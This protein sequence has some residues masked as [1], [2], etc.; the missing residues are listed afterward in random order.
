MSVMFYARKLLDIIDGSLPRELAKSQEEWMDRDAAY[1]SIIILAVDQKLMQ[2]LM[3]C[4]TANQM[5]RRL[6]TVHEQNT[7]E[8]LQLLQQKFYELKMKPSSDMV[9]H[10]NAVEQ[11]AKQLTDLGELILKQALICKIMCS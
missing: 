5:W 9:Y 7:I 11:L 6:C 10:I 1:Q 3:T 8:N 4:R 2:R